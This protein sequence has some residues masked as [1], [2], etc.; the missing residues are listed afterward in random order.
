MYLDR[1]PFFSQSIR[2]IKRHDAISIVAYFDD[3]HEINSE[4]LKGVM[5]LSTSDSIYVANQVNMWL[6]SQC[7]RVLIILT[8]HLRPIINSGQS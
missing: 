8:A 7:T 4:E 1:K 2:D 6:L 3:L 5:A